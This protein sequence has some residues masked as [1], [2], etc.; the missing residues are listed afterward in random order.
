MVEGHSA[1]TF[2]TLTYTIIALCT[3][4]SVELMDLPYSTRTVHVYMYVCMYVCMYHYHPVN[5]IFCVI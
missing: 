4:Y 2:T 3:S 5:K 1:L